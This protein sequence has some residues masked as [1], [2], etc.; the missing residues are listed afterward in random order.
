MSNYLGSMC[1]TCLEEGNKFNPRL[2]DSHIQNEG[3][4]LVGSL[5]ILAHLSTSVSQEF[6]TQ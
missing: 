2:P 4:L 3:L 5:C 1:E 6:G